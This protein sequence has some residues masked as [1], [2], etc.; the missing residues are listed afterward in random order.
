M[1]R[2]IERNDVLSMTSKLKAKGGWILQ[3]HAEEEDADVLK[4]EADKLL[5]EWNVTRAGET[6]SGDRPRLLKGGPSAL[7]RAMFDYGAVGFD[8]IHAG[9][10]KMFDLIIEWCRKYDPPLANSKRLRLFKPDKPSQTLFDIHDVLSELE[11]LRD[12][13][14]ELN[15]GGSIIIENTQAMTV[16]DVNQGS[17]SNPYAANQE[18]AIEAARQIRLRNL[19]GAIL[20]DFIGMDERSQRAR[21]LT[22]M[23]EAFANDASNAQVH[24][25]TRLGII[26]MTRKR[27][28]G[29]YSEKMK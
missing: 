12:K 19:S 2:Q 16:I 1:S 18:A 8:H 6:A 4:V 5:D 22:T 14:V 3:P 29:T 9:N 24:G 10:R 20:I 26:E 7:Y 28:S 23:E 27:R 13:R 15:G 17:A 25:F 21:I 11:V